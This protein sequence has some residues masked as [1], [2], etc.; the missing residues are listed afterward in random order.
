MT[1]HAIV[2]NDDYPACFETHAT[3]RIMSGQVSPGRILEILQIEPDRSF[4][5]GDR[6][7]QNGS[8]IHRTNGWFWST[9]TRVESRDTRRHIDTIIELLKGK[10]DAVRTLRSL[11]CQL[12]VMNFWIPASG[13]GGPAVE[14]RQMLWLGELD[15]ALWW[16]IYNLKKTSAHS[17]EAFA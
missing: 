13:N 16:D 12:D 15:I 3:L 17:N 8:K 6:Y 5:M 7:G 9:E 4:S 2:Y 14:P 11:G 10:T 1:S